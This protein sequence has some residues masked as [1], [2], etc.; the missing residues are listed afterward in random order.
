[1]H[2]ISNAAQSATLSP[3][4]DTENEHICMHQDSAPVNVQKNQVNLQV[5]AK[6]QNAGGIVFWFAC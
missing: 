2:S 6:F 3:L 1:V 5:L 4:Q